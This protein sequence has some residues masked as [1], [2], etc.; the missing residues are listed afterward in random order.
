FD[1]WNMEGTHQLF[2]FSD[3]RDEIVRHCLTSGFVG[4]ELLM[5]ER[6]RSGIETDGG[7]GR[8]VMIEK[9]EQSRHETIDR[10]RILA[11]GVRQWPR[12]EREV[13]AVGECHPVEED[14]K[15]FAVGVVFW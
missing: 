7:V 12:D 5:P 11:A 13:G 8:G 4:F 2:D 6:R 14:E 10:A 3:L 1:L 15:G 9:L